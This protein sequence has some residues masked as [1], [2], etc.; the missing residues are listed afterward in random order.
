MLARIT[1]EGDTAKFWRADAI[2]ILEPSA[3]RVPAAWPAA[4]PVERAEASSHVSL[5]AQRRWKAAVLQE[6]LDRLAD[7][8]LQVEVE[9][10]P[11]TT[12]A[13]VSATAPGSTWSPTRRAGRACGCSAPTT[14]S[15]S[16]RC[17]SRLP[18]SRRSPRP[19]RSSPGAGVRGRASSSSP[20]PAAPTPSCS[21]T[22]WCGTPG[23][24][25]DAR[26]P[27]APSPSP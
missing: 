16:T 8:D 24:S 23:T 26:T 20:R 4:A 17:R 25:T 27:A 21:S 12:S 18:R 14:S 19:R 6:Q 15:R 10:A 11:G 22:A 7:L 1:E 13:A 3:D 2:E 5:P 9:G